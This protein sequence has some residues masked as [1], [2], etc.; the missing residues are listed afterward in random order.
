MK[1]LSGIILLLLCQRRF[2]NGPHVGRV[3]RRAAL[4]YN[5][6]TGHTAEA[7]L[8]ARP[9]DG[10]QL[11]NTAARTYCRR[12]ERFPNFF[13]TTPNRNVQPN[14]RLRVR[15]L[16]TEPAR[17]A[18]AAR[19]PPRR[20]AAEGLRPPARARQR[21][22]PPARKGGA[23]ADGLGGE[24]RRGGYRQPPN[25]DAATHTRR[26]GWLGRFHRDRAEARLSLHRAR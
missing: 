1:F 18:T 8:S 26:R 3:A 21:A 25:L 5:H 13:R 14:P 23:S 24:L 7:L 22:R 4:S 10:A 6:R 12:P 15:L 9:G 17:A 20:D 16:R 2:L 11:T 19:G